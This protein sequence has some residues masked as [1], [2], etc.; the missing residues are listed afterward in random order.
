MEI[1]GDVFITL[2]ISGS[3][4]GWLV[5]GFFIGKAF[6]A[7]DHSRNTIICHSKILHKHCLQILLGVKMQG[8]PTGNFEKKT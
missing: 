3:G 6:L 2:Y 1:K 5:G 7:F 4:I 8:H